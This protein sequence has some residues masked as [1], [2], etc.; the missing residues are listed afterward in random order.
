MSLLKVN[1]IRHSSATSDAITLA[2]DGTAT[3]KITNNLSNRNILIN[4]AMKVSQRGTE[5]TGV[6]GSWG[7]KKA[8]DR[9]FFDG[10]PSGA[11][12]TVG[13]ATEA[14]A[15]FA[16][17]YK[18]QCTTADTSLAA[19]DTVLLYQRL[20]GQ[21]LQHLLKGTSD[22]KKLVLS[23]YLKTSKTGVYVINLSDIDNNRRNNKSITVSDTNWNR[24]TLVFE[25]DTTGA[26]DDDN[27]KS[28]EVT[29]WLAPGANFEGTALPSGWHANNNDNRAT[30]NVNFAD[31]TSNILYFTG[32]QLE[33]D[34]GSGVASDYEHRSYGDEVTKC[35]RYY[36]Q[37]GGSTDATNRFIIEGYTKSTSYSMVSHIDYTMR[38]APTVTQT[39]GWS[40][41]HVGSLSFNYRDANQCAIRLIADANDTC[42]YAHTDADSYLK[43]DAEL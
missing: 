18:V 12:F 35:K 32:M 10:T 26:L 24:Y 33:V 1:T 29:L 42:G 28:L 16:K 30:G 40:L 31:N 34:N 6:S 25:G 21:D 9:W 37:F 43:F 5:E 27:D 14:P 38:A 2:S 20:E 39:S 4:G 23:F 8:P 3:A 41:N 13:Q 19:S 7:Y 15:G 17:S 11:A 22:A 36:I